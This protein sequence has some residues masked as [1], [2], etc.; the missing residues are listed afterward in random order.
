MSAR[1]AFGDKTPGAAMAAL[2][3]EK[4]PRDPG[5]CGM[6]PL[7]ASKKNGLV[8]TTKPILANKGGVN[9]NDRN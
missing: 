7:N 6:G 4:I 8:K 1:I 2:D 9:L 3:Q 5:T